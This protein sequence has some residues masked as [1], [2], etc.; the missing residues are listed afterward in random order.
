M[1]TL[2]VI[3][4]EVETFVVIGFH[5]PVENYILQK[6]ISGYPF[7]SDV[8]MK[9]IHVVKSFS[10]STG[11]TECPLFKVQV[12]FSFHLGEIRNEKG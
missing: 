9:K 8:Q 7:S 11:F 10:H 2:L 1:L 4:T 6:N 5:F 12:D 3:L